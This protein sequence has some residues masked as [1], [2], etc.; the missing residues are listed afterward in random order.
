MNKVREMNACGETKPM[1]YAPFQ[2]E[3]QKVFMKQINDHID[4]KSIVQT[5]DMQCL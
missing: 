3:H 4:I 1:T 5:K 2:Q